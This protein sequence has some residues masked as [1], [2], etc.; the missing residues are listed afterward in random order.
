MKSKLKLITLLSI[1][2]LSINSN[3]VMAQSK[4]GDGE[5]RIAFKLHY[6]VK[7]GLNIANMTV[8]NAGNVSDKRAVASF[9]VGVYTDFALLPVLSLQPGLFL[10]GKGSKF[11]IGD[12]G[13]SN[14]TIVKSKPLYLELPVNLVVKIPLMNKVKL[15]AGAGPYV[16]YGITGK[17][18]TEGKLLG[19]SFSNDDNINFSND[20]LNGNNGT[21]YEGSLKH[22][23]AG[24]NVLAGIEISHFTLNANYGYGLF[25][26]KPGSVNGNDNKYQN[27]VFTVQAGVIF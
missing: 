8:D 14:Y 11:T 5:R 9:N 4:T 6:G 7:G 24:L 26:I 23:D 13:S 10:N 15:F 16:A 1:S 12:D 22:F 18:I 20:D 25:N 2:M 17:N 3:T 19:L 27:R 21:A